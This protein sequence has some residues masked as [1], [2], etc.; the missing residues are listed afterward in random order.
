M[1]ALFSSRL[2]MCPGELHIISVSVLVQGCGV[3][4]IAEPGRYLVAAAFTLATPIVNRRDV[5]LSDGT[6]AVMHFIDDGLYGSFNCILYDHQVVKPVPLD[7][8]TD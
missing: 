1:V 3:R 5:K 6:N 7:V 4:V 8:N 2:H